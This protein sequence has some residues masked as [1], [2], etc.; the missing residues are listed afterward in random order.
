PC[1]IHKMNPLRDLCNRASRNHDYD[2]MIRFLGKVKQNPIYP[3][4]KV[5]SEFNPFSISH[6][7]KDEEPLLKIADLVAHSVYQCA[8]KSSSNHFIPEYRYFQELSGRFA[9]GQNG[10]ILGIGL[11]PIHSLEMLELDKQIVEIVRN[12]RAAPPTKP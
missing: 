5:L 4:S 8:N 2:A 11:K 12:A 6:R 7:A 10:K 1:W 3:E 9:A